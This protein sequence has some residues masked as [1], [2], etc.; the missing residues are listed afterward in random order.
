MA[1]R[2]RHLLYT[3]DKLRTVIWDFVANPFRQACW[4]TCMSSSR[5]PAGHLL[6]KALH[7]LLSPNEIQA[8]S[9][10]AA[11]LVAMVRFPEPEPDQR[12]FPWPL[13]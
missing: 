3:E 10:R 6:G 7:T 11:R 5:K 9:D 13:L 12:S 4:T 2:P 1:D 8:L